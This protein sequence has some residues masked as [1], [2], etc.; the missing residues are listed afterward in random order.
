[1]PLGHPANPLDPTGAVIG[2]TELLRSALRCLAAD[3]AFDMVLLAIPTWG[4]YD[5]RRLMPEFI[6]C[7]RSSAKPTVIS[8]W[9]A[10]A[11]TAYAEAMLRDSGV[12]YYES[13]DAAVTT[14]ANLYRFHSTRPTR[15]VQ[16]VGSEIPRAS[17][18]DTEYRSKL[19]L[20]QQGVNVALERVA[21]SRTELSRL[22]CELSWPLVAKLQCVGV[23]HKTEAG[24]V[25]TGIRSPEELDRCLRRFDEVAAAS[26][27]TVDSYLVAEQLEGFEM[28]VGTVWDDTFGPTIMIGAGGI[29][30]EQFDDRAFRLCPLD[31]T[32]ALSAVRKLRV[33]SV[34]EGAR[35]G[36]YA[37][38]A[39]AGLVQ[40]V[41]QIA[42]SA[43]WIREIDLNPVIVGKTA[44][45]VA[46]AV[47]V[48]SDQLQEGHRQNQ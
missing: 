22:A 30:A 45:V 33:A 31:E 18:L 25:Q 44:A 16:S 34:L 13:A 2:N 46:D 7:A 21:D 17:P 24:L 3:P 47:I 6:E 23:T 4:E 10:G 9:G 26:Q 19:F 39:F 11:M 38:G 5:A 43:P 27:L 42:A 37:L 40:R 48:R 28:I 20:A 12:L 1:M 36:R 8:A 29:F 35:G 32:E 14:L 41:S 15:Q